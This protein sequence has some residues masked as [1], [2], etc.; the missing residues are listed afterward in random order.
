MINTLEKVP[1]IYLNK[2]FY[3]LTGMN[4]KLAINTSITRFQRQ[5][6]V[7]AKSIFAHPR[8]Y[9]DFTYI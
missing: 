6:P 3:L 2:L 9:H 7:N 1:S 5:M 8:L 4:W